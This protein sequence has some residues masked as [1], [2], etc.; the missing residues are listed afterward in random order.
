MCVCVCVCVFECVFVCVPVCA[1]VC[2]CVCV[3][4][5]VCVCAR[6]CDG[7]RG[8]FC[9]RNCTDLGSNLVPTLACLD[10][11]NFSHLD[12]I[13]YAIGVSQPRNEQQC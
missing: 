8:W 1:C 10:V 12:S 2:I 6:V 4:V 11:N 13:A 5:F 9:F 7:W 3:C